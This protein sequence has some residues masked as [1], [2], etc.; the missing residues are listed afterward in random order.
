MDTFAH[1]VKLADAVRARDR[2]AL[3]STGSCI[4]G[5]LDPNDHH[6]ETVTSALRSAERFIARVRAEKARAPS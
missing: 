5:S 6:D 2:C 1:L 4:G 3:S